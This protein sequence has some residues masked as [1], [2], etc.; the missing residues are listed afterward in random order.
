MTKGGLLEMKK[1]RCIMT[2]DDDQNMLR[3]LSRLLEVEGYGV[4]LATDGKSALALL[5]KRRPDLIILDIMMPKVDG[6]QVLD[7]LRQRSSVPVIMLTGRH[8]VTSLQKA[9]TL[10]ADDYVIKPFSTR[11]LLARIRAKLRRARPVRHISNKKQ[12]R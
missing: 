6:F 12:E 9:L 5:E 10:G 8:E 4:T 1:R 2:V 7:S 3:M 11:E